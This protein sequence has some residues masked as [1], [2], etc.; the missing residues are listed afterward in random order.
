MSKLNTISGSPPKT[1]GEKVDSLVRRRESAKFELAKT[2]KQLLEAGVKIGHQETGRIT[3]PASFSPYLEQYEKY[4]NLEFLWEARYKDGGTLNQWEGSV[5]HL[6]TDID[7][8]RLKELRL[9]SLFDYP[10]TNQEKRQIITLHWETGVITFLNGIIPQDIKGYCATPRPKGKS[11]QLVLKKRL[12]RS[13][14]TPVDPNSDLLPYFTSIDE[15]YLYN[16]W[17][18]GWQV[19]GSKQKKVIIV[20]PNGEVEIGE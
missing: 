17:I 1:T 4:G 12:R 10:T 3:C 15:F 20:N 19:K 2:T 5:E 6:W 18:F 16:R 14:N 8:K 9:V 13:F 7:Q 11:I